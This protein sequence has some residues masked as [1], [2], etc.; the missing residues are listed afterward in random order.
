M[1]EKHVMDPQIILKWL[2]N[3]SEFFKLFGVYLA[4]QEKSSSKKTVNN[5]LWRVCQICPKDKKNA[6]FL[7]KVLQNQTML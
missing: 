4:R 7:Y 3:F 2:V 1:V 5:S 6:F